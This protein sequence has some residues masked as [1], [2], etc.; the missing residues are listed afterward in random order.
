M[1]LMAEWLE[2]VSQWHEMYCYGMAVM[3]LKPGQV[4]L[5]CA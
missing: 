4:E 2:Y 1:T 3:S 5:G